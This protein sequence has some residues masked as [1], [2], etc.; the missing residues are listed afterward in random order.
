M[1]C[2]DRRT[3]MGHIKMES[4]IGGMLSQTKEHLGLPETRMGKEDPP[5]EASEGA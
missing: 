5:T 4:E 3:E 2:E 1:T